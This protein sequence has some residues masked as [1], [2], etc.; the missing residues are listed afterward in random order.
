MGSVSCT[1][2]VDTA[3]RTLVSVLKSQLPFILET[4]LLQ[5]SGYNNLL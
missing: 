2:L 4:E 3:F 5:S 1:L